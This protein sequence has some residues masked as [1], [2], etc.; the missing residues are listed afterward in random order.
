MLIRQQRVDFDS[1]S[2][3]RQ[4]LVVLGK[5]SCVLELVPKSIFVLLV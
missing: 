5:Y 1:D 2:S 3:F 4:K